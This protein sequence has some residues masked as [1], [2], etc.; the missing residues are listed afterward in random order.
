M[1]PADLADALVQPGPSLI[2][3]YR[4][5]VPQI[6]QNDNISQLQRTLKTAGTNAIGEAERAQ[7][8]QLRAALERVAPI[9]LS[10]QDAAQRAGGRLMTTPSPHTKWRARKLAQLLMPLTPS[11]SRL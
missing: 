5:T 11:M 9:D 1:R 10:V 8:A 7:Q 4:P 6:M 3:G 2:P